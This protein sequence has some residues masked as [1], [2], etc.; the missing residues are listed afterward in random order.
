MLSAQISASQKCK[1][2]LNS[3]DLSGSEFAKKQRFDNTD[4]GPLN[5]KISENLN[6]LTS[7]R[8]S[9]DKSNTTLKIY[10]YKVVK[11]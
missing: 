4:L 7:S 6:I 11:L 10:I 9:K 1:L 5:E 3:S 8:N 2:D